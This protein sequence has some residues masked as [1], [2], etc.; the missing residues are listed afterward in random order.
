MSL[1]LIDNL[2]NILLI[3]LANL[4]GFDLINSYDLLSLNEVSCEP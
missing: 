3:N 1:N 2:S 4:L